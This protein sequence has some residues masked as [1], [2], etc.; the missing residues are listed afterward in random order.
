M[1][2]IISI[3]AISLLP[4]AMAFAQKEAGDV[5]RGNRDYKSQDFIEA[6]VNY[7]RGHQAS[8]QRHHCRTV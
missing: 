4:F 8:D 3:L 5:R 7:R 2:K 6:E 1:R